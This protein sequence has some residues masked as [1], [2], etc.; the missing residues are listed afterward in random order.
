MSNTIDT[1][2]EPYLYLS[3]Y[4]ANLVLK[5]LEGAFGGFVTFSRGSSLWLGL[6]VIFV[7][8]EIAA[9]LTGTVATFRLSKLK[10]FIPLIVMWM[11]PGLSNTFHFASLGPIS[12]DD[13]TMIMWGSPKLRSTGSSEGMALA[14]SF[15]IISG[16]SVSLFLFEVFRAGKRLRLI[17]EHG[18]ILAGMVTAF[19][20]VLEVQSNI[21][22]E[23]L[24]DAD[25]EVVKAT[26]LLYEKVSS[27]S[28][29]CA[30]DETRIFGSIRLSDDFCSW[31]ESAS[32]LIYTTR[33]S[34]DFERVGII[35]PNS[36]DFLQFYRPRSDINFADDILAQI[37]YVDSYYCNTKSEQI[38]CLPLPGSLGTDLIAERI[39]S[40]T[41]DIF[42]RHA[43]PIVQLV[44]IV[45][46]FTKKGRD[47][48]ELRRAQVGLPNQRWL[49]IFALAWLAGAKIAF[50]TRELFRD[51]LGRP[52]AAG[53]WGSP[54]H[55]AM[56][57]GLG[58]PL[59]LLMRFLTGLSK[60]FRILLRIFIKLF[61]YFQKNRTNSTIDPSIDREL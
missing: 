30:R 50:A 42:V 15:S 6:S 27:L 56:L 39:T 33:Y 59:R 20:L 52:H 55:I 5:N 12:L 18:W 49:S 34:F 36:Q 47:L 26:T 45:H 57:R 16:W 13:R 14:L 44:E 48:F 32:A 11:L 22:R 24:T 61:G 25:A 3:A 31:S 2:L 19:F 1:F 17:F 41:D 43:F 10:L 28:K 29:L 60:I 23:E 51:D 58:A 35:F 7:C 8:F 37:E 9:L 53:K 38:S 54:V 40:D 4:L 21:T 46:E